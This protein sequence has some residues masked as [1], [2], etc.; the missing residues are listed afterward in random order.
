MD[1]EAS[2][3][4]F[5]T[6]NIFSKI[7]CFHDNGNESPQLPASAGRPFEIFHAFTILPVG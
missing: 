1:W 6:G 7:S 5:W 4:D 3:I 2:D